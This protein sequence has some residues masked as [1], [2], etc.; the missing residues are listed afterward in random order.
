MALR[1]TSPQALEHRVVAV[2]LYGRM[3]LIKIHK[4]RPVNLN[5]KSLFTGFANY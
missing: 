5:D 1:T 4:I 2:I 3:Y